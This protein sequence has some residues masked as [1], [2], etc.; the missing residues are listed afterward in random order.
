MCFRLSRD[1]RV[2]K[3]KFTQVLEYCFYYEK[4][5]SFYN[6]ERCKFFK[7]GELFYISLDPVNE[8]EEIDERDQDIIMC[9]QIEG[10]MEQ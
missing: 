6:V 10:Y 4:S 5:R 7:K 9:K 2:L 1:A 3:I 8:V